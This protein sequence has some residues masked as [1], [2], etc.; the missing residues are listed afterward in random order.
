VGHP[1]GGH[2]LLLHGFQ[3]S[4]LCLGRG[5]VYLVGQDDVGEYGT[6]D[7]DHA[8]A[9]LGLLQDLAAGD[10]GRHQVGRELDALEFQ[11]EQLG[12]RF[13]QQGL[14][15]PR[16]ARQ[17]AVA[18]RQDRH[19]QLIDDRALAD[20]HLAQFGGDPLPRFAQLGHRRPL[21][22]VLLLLLA[23]RRRH[24]AVSPSR[25]RT[26]SSSSVAAVQSDPG[27]WVMA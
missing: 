10:V 23:R 19:Q 14:G 13:D 18:A 21:L 12:Q 17:Q 6:L 2:L 1:G 4:G 3:E 16:R 9:L 22:V 15:Q 5:A 8:P 26:P 24:V 11:V 7:E 20:D 25:C 27:Q